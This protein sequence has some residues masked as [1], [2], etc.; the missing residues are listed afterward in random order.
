M[1][2]RIAFVA[3]LIFSV[4]FSACE[5]DEATP[6]LA[7]LNKYIDSNSDL[8][9]STDLIACAAGMPTGFMGDTPHP[10]SVFFYPV[11][12]AY[13]FRYWETS[14]D[15]ADITDYDLFKLKSLED[16]PVLNGKLWRFKNTSF[17]GTRW[18]IV[19]YKTEGKLHVCRAINL[20]TNPKPT[21][22]AP[23]LITITENGVTPSFEWE[24]GLWDDNVIYFQVVSD[25]MGNIVSGTYTTDLN[26]TFYDLSNVVLNVHDVTPEPS[27][28]PNS[29]YN[30]LLMSVS[31][32]NWV[33]LM[34]EKQFSTN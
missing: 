6:V 23:E 1:T 24:D 20:K 11:T 31:Y 8:E 5:R 10:T 3:F 29:T 19:T 21:Q 26:W 13:E 32:D 28:Q 4:S 16:E 15:I 27:L 12:G 14:G 9:F 30:F 25:T 33:N 18:G 34:G 2:A 17:E 7:T 22:V